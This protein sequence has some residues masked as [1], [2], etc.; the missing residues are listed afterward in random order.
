[1]SDPRLLTLASMALL[2]QDSLLRTVGPQTHKWMS[3]EDI[4]GVQ[5]GFELTQ[6]MQ[7]LCTP[8]LDW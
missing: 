3:F 5:F 4:A 1:M 8:H 2:G 7:L 6:S